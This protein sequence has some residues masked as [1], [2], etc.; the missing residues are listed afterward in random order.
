MVVSVNPEVVP[1]TEEVKLPEASELG[2]FAGLIVLKATG[3]VESLKSTAVKLNAA[4]NI[5]ELLSEAIKSST[6]A[7]V[8][9]RRQMIEKANEK[10]LEWMKANEEAVKPTLEVPSDEEIKALEEVYKAGVKNFNSLDNL[11]VDEVS[12]TYPNLS[13]SNYVGEL[14]KGR[15]GSTGA[16][17]GQGEGTSRPRVSSIEVSTDNGETYKKIEKEVEKD[18]KKVLISTFTTAVAWLK[19]ETE[20]KVNLGAGDLHE[21][22]LEQNGVKDWNDLPEVSTFAY[23]ANDTTWFFRVTK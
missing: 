19:K 6:D 5:G 17:A 10:I 4:G 1:E 15:R 16:K 20:N 12:A 9:Q 23:S 7:D 3:V 11:F 13:L 21:P 8:I 18:G 14:P 2:E 22:W